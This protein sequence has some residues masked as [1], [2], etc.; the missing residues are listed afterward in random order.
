MNTLTFQ[1]KVSFFMQVCPTLCPSHEKKEDATAEKAYITE[2]C[3]WFAY[4][5]LPT[6]HPYYLRLFKLLFHTVIIRYIKK[7]YFKHF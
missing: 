1:I 3:I 7:F 4:T 2:F 5:S 6:H